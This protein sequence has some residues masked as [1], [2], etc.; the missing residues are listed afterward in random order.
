MNKKFY[1][2]VGIIAL[3]CSILFI[4]DGIKNDWPVWQIVTDILVPCVS[5]GI[6]S[7]NYAPSKKKLNVD[8]LTPKLRRLWFASFFLLCIGES[9]MISLYRDSYWFYAIGALMLISFGIIQKYILTQYYK[10]E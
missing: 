5:I 2:Y 10:S 6:M 4:P 7:W 3:F 8:N 9:F 1:L